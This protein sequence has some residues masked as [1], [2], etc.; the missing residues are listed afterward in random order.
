MSKFPCD[1]WTKSAERTRG[2]S[3][4]S[5]VLKARGPRR[6]LFAYVWQ[7]VQVARRVS[8]VALSLYFHKVIAA[9]VMCLEGESPLQTVDKIWA[10]SVDG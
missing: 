2:G 8:V 5:V 6:P 9:L 1:V 10:A 7:Q 4:L 3:E